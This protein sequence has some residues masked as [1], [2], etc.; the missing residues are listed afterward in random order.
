MRVFPVTREQAS[1]TQSPASPNEIQPSVQ[2]SAN[3]CQGTEDA[4]SDESLG[5][6]LVSVTHF[7]S[8][9]G[10]ALLP[11]ILTTQPLGP[12]ENDPQVRVIGGPIAT[13]TVLTPTR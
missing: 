9:P 12:G 13:F 7:L 2:K 4:D 6:G 1:D 8:L 3:G 11:F 10:A 5:T